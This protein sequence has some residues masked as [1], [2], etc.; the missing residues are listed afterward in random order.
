LRP[1]TFLGVKNRLFCHFNDPRRQRLYKFINDVDANASG[2]ATVDIWPSIN[3]APSDNDPI[4]ILN[5]VGLFRL[6]SNQMP[7]TVNEA[8]HY[9]LV[10]PAM[11][12]I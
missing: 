6:S 1:S 7:W 8:L 11:S 3:T 9:G 2:E 10:I 4:A 12:L 5:T